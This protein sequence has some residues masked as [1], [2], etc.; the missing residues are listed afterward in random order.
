MAAGFVLRGYGAEDT[1]RW[2]GTSDLHGT[3]WGAF[4]AVIS[5]G[6]G[7]GPGIL[8]LPEV[9]LLSR[10][11]LRFGGACWLSIFLGGQ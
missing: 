10:W 7:R 8:K 1:S 2:V 5:T 3:D 9:A 6:R 11:Y 4:E